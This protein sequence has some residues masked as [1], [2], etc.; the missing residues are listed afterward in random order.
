MRKNTNRMGRV[1]EEFKKE[2]SHIITYELSNSDITGMV[3]VTRVETTPDLRYAKVYVSI[4]GSKNIEKTL[5]GLQKASGFV[6][7]RVAETVNLRI[8]PEIRFVYDDSDVI[9]ERIDKIIKEARENDETIKA[10]NKS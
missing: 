2:I 5:K 7:H 9:G 4:L 8:T 10:Q 3:S 6:R 1:N